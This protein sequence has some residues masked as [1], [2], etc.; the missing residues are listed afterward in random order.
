MDMPQFLGFLSILC[1]LT[2]I[3]EQ[4]CSLPGAEIQP[5]CT[6]AGILH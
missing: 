4:I 1:V 6:D 5:S 2:H 3:L